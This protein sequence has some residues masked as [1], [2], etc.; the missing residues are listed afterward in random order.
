VV[1]KWQAFRRFLQHIERYTQVADAR[2]QFDLYLPYAIAFG[3]ER[4]LV[5]KFAAANTPAPSWYEPNPFILGGHPAY[6]GAASGA[7]I[8]TGAVLADGSLP[9]LDNMAQNMGMTLDAI[10]MD[11]FNMLDVTASAFTSQVSLFDSANAG[12]DGLFSWIGGDNDDGSIFGS[13]DWSGGGG[14]GGGSS[15]FG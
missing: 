4:S 2:S 9:S 10:S 8:G 6:Y 13:G 12:E 7:G 3:L 5:E 1:A 11:F 15:G 14:F